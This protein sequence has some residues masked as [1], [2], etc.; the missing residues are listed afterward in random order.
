MCQFGRRLPIAC[1]PE[2]VLLQMGAV[3]LGVPAN[4][5]FGEDRAGFARDRKLDCERR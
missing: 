1:G 5:E 4:V 2:V 3:R